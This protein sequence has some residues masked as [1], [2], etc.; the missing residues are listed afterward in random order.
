MKDLL[1]Q[2][3]ADFALVVRTEGTLIA[4]TGT[5]ITDEIENVG[6]SLR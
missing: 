1:I 5:V 4:E 2:T 3:G 6:I